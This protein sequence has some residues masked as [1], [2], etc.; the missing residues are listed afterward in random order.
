MRMIGRLW[1]RIEIRKMMRTMVGEI[2]REER[3]REVR[4]KRE[5]GK[6]MDVM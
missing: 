4:E 2:G 1:R 3:R 6:M 5:V